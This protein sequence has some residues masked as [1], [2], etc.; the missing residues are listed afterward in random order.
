MDDIAE[1][2]SCADK[3]F[4]SDRTT[5]AMEAQAIH[6]ELLEERIQSNGLASASNH[7]TALREGPII[8]EDLTSPKLRLS[9][10]RPD[11]QC[12]NL[13]MAT[14]RCNPNDNSMAE[15]DGPATENGG[16]VDFSSPEADCNTHSGSGP[17]CETWVD[18]DSPVG[19]SSP[20]PFSISQPQPDQPS[21]GWVRFTSSESPFCDSPFTAQM[22]S[23]PVPGGGGGIRGVKPFPAR[24]RTFGFSQRQLNFT[25]K[26][27]LEK[28]AHLWG[29]S[30]RCYATKGSQWLEETDLT[31]PKV[32]SSAK[33]HFI[34]L[35]TLHSAIK[36]WQTD[37][38]IPHQL[39]NGKCQ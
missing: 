2:T 22:Q 16:W 21:P 12:S 11:P 38:I 33:I 5:A 25:D 7:N 29:Q 1:S 19:I 17:L 18:P 39:C 32:Q 6:N 24:P 26:I 31:R 8:Q 3:Y 35:F 13:G 23:P 27:R 37:T 9:Q 36:I 34:N 20:Q 28:D 4:H 10:L 14:R 30:A 15:L